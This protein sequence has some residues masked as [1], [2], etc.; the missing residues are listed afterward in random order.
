M[1]IGRDIKLKS[2]GLYVGDQK[3]D[4]MPG[5]EASTRNA[6]R[7]GD[8]VV[9]V[10]PSP[11]NDGE[12]NIC[13]YQS[14]TEAYMWTQIPTHYRR[15]FA[16]LIDH[17]MLESGEYYVIQK[18]CP[19]DDCSA[20]M[21]RDMEDVLNKMGLMAD[22]CDMPEHNWFWSKGN[23]VVVDY[24]SYRSLWDV[25]GIAEFR[26]TREIGSIL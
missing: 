13:R 5:N 21:P 10:D 11:I 22:L 24:G 15:F 17:G 7:W 2:D 9:K 3:A 19:R 14:W 6:Y 20:P 18:F 1:T 26:E 16:E 25:D 8:Y 4:P 12:R 23:P